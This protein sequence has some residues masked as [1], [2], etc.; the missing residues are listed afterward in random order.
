M[1]PLKAHEI[2]GN[3]ATL[4]LPLNDDDSVNYKQLEEQ[5]DVLISCRVNGIYSLGTAGEFYNHM[6][7]EFDQIQTTLASKCNVILSENFC[8]D[9]CR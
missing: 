2:Y 5:I 9:A 4:L 7:E 1:K 6:E 3:W 8:R